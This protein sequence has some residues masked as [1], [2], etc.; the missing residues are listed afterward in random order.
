[1]E[2]TDR[3]TRDIQVEELLSNKGGF[4]FELCARNQRIIQQLGG[5]A[6]VLPKAWSTGTTI[7]GIVIKD[8]IVLGADTRATGGSEVMDKNCEKIHY[9]APN[10]WCCGAGTAADTEK[11]TELIASNLELLRLSTGSQSR[12]VTALTMLKRMLHKY[13]IVNSDPSH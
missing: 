8:G 5:E 13:F 11:T 9:L 4:S 1:M 7:C 10:I 2:V 3:Q 12:T 6:S